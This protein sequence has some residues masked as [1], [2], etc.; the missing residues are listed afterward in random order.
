MKVFSWKKQRKENH[1]ESPDCTGSR[2]GYGDY[3]QW[4]IC[5]KKGHIAVNSFDDWLCLR[6]WTGYLMGMRFPIKDADREA[7]K[8]GG[9]IE[10]SY[11]IGICPKDL[12]F[13]SKG[14]LNYAKIYET[15]S[16]PFIAG[17]EI[18]SYDEAIARRENTVAP[19]KGGPPYVYE[20]Q[21]IE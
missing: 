14:S 17:T 3:Q 2:D 18:I 13:S 11:V 8:K 16:F 9:L 1:A 21:R 7:F 12:M 6:C 5:K 15:G 4:L 10:G 19:D 20:L